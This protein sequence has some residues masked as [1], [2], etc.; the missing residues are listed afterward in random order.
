MPAILVG[1]ADFAAAA[2]AALEAVA[3]FLLACAAIYMF[4]GIIRPIFRIGTVP[5]HEE[6]KVSGR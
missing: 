1:L 6:S 5:T 3:A 2:L 4:V